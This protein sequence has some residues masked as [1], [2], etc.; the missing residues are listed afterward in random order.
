MLTWLVS[1]LS[2]LIEKI[3][4]AIVGDL[5]KQLFSWLG[6]LWQR[7]EKEIEQEKQAKQQEQVATDPHSSDQEKK[8]A[9]NGLL[10]S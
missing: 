3:G 9:A 10:N 1:L 8:D 6:S 2:P 5:I 4:L 7:H